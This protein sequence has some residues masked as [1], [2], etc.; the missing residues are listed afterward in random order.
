[1]LYLINVYIFLNHLQLKME[2]GI[3]CLDNFGLR[4]TSWAT[5]SSYAFSVYNN[6]SL[7]AL[8]S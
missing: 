5:T 3:H 8:L 2:E 7:S 4:L 6:I 1:M